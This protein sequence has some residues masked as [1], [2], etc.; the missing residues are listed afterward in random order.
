MKTDPTSYHI[1]KY[2]Y[3]TFRSLGVHLYDIELGN[4]FLGQQKHKRHTEF[5]LYQ[6]KTSVFQ[7]ILSRK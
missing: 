3:K 7:R 2:K 4:D 1:D 6:T 5:G